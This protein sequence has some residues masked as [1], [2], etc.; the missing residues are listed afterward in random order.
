MALSLTEILFKNTYFPSIYVTCLCIHRLSRILI[1][2]PDSESQVLWNFCVHK[3]LQRFD[4]TMETR[5]DLKR[6]N[7]NNR[8]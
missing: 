4:L 5:L 1:L 3:S 7:L 6:G 8:Y 2:L